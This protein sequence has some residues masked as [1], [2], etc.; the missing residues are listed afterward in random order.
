M[1]PKLRA[2][3]KKDERMSYGV[4]MYY[5]DMINYRFDHFCTGADEDVEFMQSTGL[6]DKNGTEVYEGDIVKCSRGCPH[7]I[8]WEKELGGTYIGGMP[9]WYLSGL[10]EGYAWTGTEEIIGNIYENPELLEGAEK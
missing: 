7:L 3:D 9:A 8:Y 4:V 2:W 1:I 6:K 5:D 10:N